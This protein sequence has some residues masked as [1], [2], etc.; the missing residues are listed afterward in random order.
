MS[1]VVHLS[2]TDLK[3]NSYDVD[4]DVNLTVG[5]LKAKMAKEHNIDDPRKIKLLYSSHILGDT[6]ILKDLNLN[7]SSLIKAHIS[8]SIIQKTSASESSSSSKFIQRTTS[9]PISK[10]S[11]HP[12]L[13]PRA[14][15]QFIQ[16][17]EFFQ[18]DQLSSSQTAPN[19][20]T[21][22]HDFSQ[23]AN[24]DLIMKIR[25]ALL[26]QGADPTKVDNFIYITGNSLN[27]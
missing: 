24:Y 19:Q 11:N 26:E 25:S 2:I 7:S 1:E 14:N 6:Q 16:S 4:I 17:P 27:D 23:Y 8:G 9:Q 20:P 10:S 3:K 12:N 21:P 13:P 15:S 18:F 5:D 22:N